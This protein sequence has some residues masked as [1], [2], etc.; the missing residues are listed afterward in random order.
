M[1]RVRQ[2]YVYGVCA[3]SLLFLATGIENL[4]RLLIQIAAGLDATPW[5][6]L[7][8]G[9]LRQQLSFFVALTA[10]NAPVWVGHWLA[11][12]RGLGVAE[13]ASPIRRLYLY[14][15]LAGALFFFVPGAI[16]LIRTPLWALLGAPIGQ[17][18][19]S[20]IAAPIGLIAVTVPIWCYHRRLAITDAAYSG[21]ADALATIR[22]LYLYAASFILA[23]LLLVNLARLGTSFW[24]GMIRVIGRSTVGDWSW[25]SA[26]LPS[27]GAATI[28]LLGLWWWHW[29]NAELIASRDDAVGVSERRSRLRLLTLCG[30]VLVFLIVAAVNAST[31]LNDLFRAALGSADPAGKGRGLVD[32]LGQPIVWGLIYGAF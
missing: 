15:A 7:S 17:P 31:L 8:R 21:D 20:A 12:S 3:V 23:N 16:G 19:L 1:S 29:A 11:A 6:W 30:L 18:L 22:R 2:L 26:S 5:L 9:A 4:I 27:L 32:A 13:R 14:L 28:V 25:A 24:E 10:I